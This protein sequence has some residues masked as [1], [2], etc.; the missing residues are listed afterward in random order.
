MSKK[1][2]LL[3]IKLPFFDGI[4]SRISVT[5]GQGFYKGDLSNISYYNGLVKIINTKTMI[6]L[7]EEINRL[8]AVV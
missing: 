4:Y 3:A 1:G 6:S 7:E 5:G 2:W 8:L